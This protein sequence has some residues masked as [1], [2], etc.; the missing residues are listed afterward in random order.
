[1]LRRPGRLI[2][3]RGTN[4]VLLTVQINPARGEFSLGRRRM[5]RRAIASGIA[6]PVGIC[7]FGYQSTFH[8][9][10]STMS[11][12]SNAITPGVIHGVMPPY[13]L[14]HDLMAATIAALP[15][16]PPDST[17]AWRQARLTRLLEEVAALRPADAAQARLA[18]QLLTTRELADAY[19]ARAHAP[20]LD[21]D[22]MCRL[23]RAAVDLLRS[24]AT[25]DRVLARQQQMP[26][27]LFGNVVQDEVDLPAPKAIR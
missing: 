11:I 13:R 1:V 4:P 6:Q 8:R 27:A 26:V 16:P 23:G 5:S 20:G 3:F 12:P 15:A 10:F 17:P 2:F 14:S 19:V 18:A 7:Y 24:A 25:L 22:Q 9:S 21:I